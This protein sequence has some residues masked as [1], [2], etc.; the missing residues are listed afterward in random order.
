[1]PDYCTC[2]TQLVENASF[3]HRC[4][5]P[6]FEAEIAEA[7]AP[8]PPRPPTLQ[9]KLAQI[10]VSFSNP[11][12]LRVAFL[13][14]LATMLL[15]MIPVLGLL[16][17]LWWL[18]AG[19]GA[20]QIYRRITGLSLS[21]SAGAR[22]GSITGVLAFVGTVLLLTLQMVFVG[23][24]F[25]DEMIQQDPRMKQVI[26]DPAMLATVCLVMLALVFSLVVGICAAGGALGARFSARKTS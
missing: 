4:G 5:R 18:A 25:L 21:V 20:V 15:E 11:I 16:S 10:P 9:E 7:P 26:A 22:L 2:G 23:K 6:T 12:A 19:W 13:M 14:S 24:Q 1:M 8:T 3:C 17:F